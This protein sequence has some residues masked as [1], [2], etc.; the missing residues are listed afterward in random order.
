MTTK[1]KSK[2]VPKKVKTIQ[3]SWVLQAAVP[4]KKGSVS[5][6]KSK[7]AVTGIWLQQVRIWWAKLMKRVRKYI[8]SAKVSRKLNWVLL[9]CF[10]QVIKTRKFVGAATQANKCSSAT[11][12]CFK[13]LAKGKKVKEEATEVSFHS[14][15]NSVFVMVWLEIT[16]AVFSHLISLMLHRSRTTMVNDFHPMRFQT[17]LS[18]RKFNPIRISR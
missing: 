18:L 16:K 2:G 14:R 13:R 9:K 6:K 4:A 15:I 12:Q 8:V 3:R 7:C 10:E 11:I 17:F 1:L 5:P